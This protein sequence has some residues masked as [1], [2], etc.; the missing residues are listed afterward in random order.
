M[1]IG[2]MYCL[3]YHSSTKQNKKSKCR[4]VCFKVL[5]CPARSHNVGSLLRVITY[6]DRIHNIES[7]FWDLSQSEVIKCRKVFHRVLYYPARGWMVCFKVLLCPGKS[8]NVV[9]SKHRPSGP[10]LSISRNV[11]PSV[12]PCVHF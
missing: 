10:M 5:A 6:P 2:L 11:R 4:K 3:C 9:F 1:C 7:L 12:C 8:P